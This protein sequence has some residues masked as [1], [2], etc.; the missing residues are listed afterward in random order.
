MKKMQAQARDKST[1][2][3]ADL[4]ARSLT[5]TARTR[6]HELTQRK[7]LHKHDGT[8]REPGWS[9][10]P[11]Q[12]YSRAGVKAP[13]IRLKEWD[14][15]LVVGQGFGV[16]LTIADNGYMGLNSVTFMDYETAGSIDKS[17]P[18]LFP[19]GKYGMPEDS[20]VPSVS[21]FE[22]STLKLRFDVREGTRRLSCRYKK[23]HNGR[24]FACEITL[25]EP[26]MDSL[27]IATPWA[28]DPLA[29]YYNRKIN[30]MP[31]GGWV[32]LDGERHEF[33]PY[34]DFGTLDWGRGVWTYD[35]RWKWGSG[36]GV[37]DGKPFGFNLGYGFGDTRAASENLLIYDGIGHKI[38]DVTFHFDKND[39]TKPWRWDSSD[40]RLEGDFVPVFDHATKVDAKILCTD[41]H[42]VFGK[43]T[44]F[45]VLDDGRRLELKD[46]FCFAE[47]VRMKY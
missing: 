27:T 5:G 38:D 6:S 26:D 14:Y 44:G 30:C 20:T 23:F 24:D 34:T 39:Y 46:F 40:G 12:I 11:V 33:N 32:E 15:Y 31:A 18:T 29:F 42:Q 28:E 13:K 19:M 1:E 10:R 16:A 17:V 2:I 41:G 4:A 37:V 35:N 9:R 8:L 3:S 47:D 25:A 43:L 7:T 22:N 36:N 21:S 45:C